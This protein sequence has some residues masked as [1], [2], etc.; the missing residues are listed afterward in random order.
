MNLPADL[1]HDLSLPLPASWPLSRICSSHSGTEDEI[2]AE[3]DQDLMRLEYKLSEV[4]E[5]E[6]KGN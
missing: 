4:F 5:I 1:V 6:H 2:V 3:M